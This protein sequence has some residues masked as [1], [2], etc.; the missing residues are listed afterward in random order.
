MNHGILDAARQGDRVKVRQLIAG[1]ADVNTA[2][3]NGTTA[4][5][6]AAD[7]RHAITI[8]SL[9][10]AGADVNAKDKCDRTPLIIAVAKRCTPEVVQLLVDAGADVNAKEG[11]WTPLMLAAHAAHNGGQADTIKILLDAGADV[12]PGITALD[13]VKRARCSESIH[14]LEEAEKS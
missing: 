2:D 13:M 12:K 5:M 7:S 6:W 11:N 3:K 9:V 4:L 8:Q 10:D 1:G 14:L